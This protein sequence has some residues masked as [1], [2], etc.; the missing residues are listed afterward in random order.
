LSHSHLDDLCR[1][2]LFN[3]QVIKPE[4]KEG[5]KETEKEKHEK[6]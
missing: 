4:H 3:E 5:E 2:D 6:E 1:N